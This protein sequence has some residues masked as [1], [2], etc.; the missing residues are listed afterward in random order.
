MNPESIWIL[1]GVLFLGG[2]IGF[3][4]SRKPRPSAIG[5]E[6]LRGNAG[7]RDETAQYELQSH[8]RDQAG[9]DADQHKFNRAKGF[10]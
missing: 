4:A 10:I 8:Q 5:D 7:A 9:D 6:R 1:L 2:A 3:Y